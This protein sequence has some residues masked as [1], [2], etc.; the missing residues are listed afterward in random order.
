MT[1]VCL[2]SHQIF[3]P[4]FVFIGLEHED[5]CGCCGSENC[6][7]RCA[8]GPSALVVRTGFLPVAGTLRGSLSVFLLPLDAVFCAGGSHRNRRIWL[9]RHR[10]SPGLNSR[11]SVSRFQQPMELYLFGH[12]RTVSSN[13]SSPDHTFLPSTCV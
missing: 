7:K 6:G 4:A 9:L 8:V 10:G 3:L 13:G 5:C 11:T 12:R 2:F 1:P